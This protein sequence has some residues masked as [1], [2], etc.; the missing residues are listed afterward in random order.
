[1]IWKPVSNRIEDDDLF[2]CLPKPCRVRALRRVGLPLLLIGCPC[3]AQT[4]PARPAGVLPHDQNPPGLNVT[5]R[6]RG[7]KTTF[8]LFQAIPIELAFS[9]TK[10]SVYSIELDEAM[11][12]AGNTNSFEVSPADSVVLT[13]PAGATGAT[14]CC[15]SDRRYLSAQPTVLVRELTDYFRFEKPGT[16]SVQYFTR[17]VFRG[18]GSS[19]DFNASPLTVT[20]NVLALTIL[21]DDRDW[22]ARTLADVLAKLDDPRIR[23]SYIAGAKRNK[24]LD[25]ETAQDFAVENRL[26]QMEFALAQKTLNT[27][28]TEEAIH[29]RVHRMALESKSDRDASRR[30]GS[31]ALLPQP[32]L[33]ST[34]RPDLVATALKEQAEQPDFAVSGGYV[35]RWAQFLVQRD[36]PEIFRLNGDSYAENQDNLRHYATYLY[37]AERGLVQ[38]LDSLLPSKQREAAEATSV[39]I[40]V[41]RKFSAQEPASPP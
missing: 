35:Y 2:L 13:S 30:F 18:L 39:T 4:N 1:L 12:F 11:N 8:H 25:S 28:D 26:D 14:I 24:R 16:Y 37:E 21:D 3:A 38:M 5:L 17:R 6:T 15:A 41:V 36:H 19:N 7:A 20:S 40:R 22:D 23:Q 34:T 10:P 33:R 9:S 27:L 32:L 29:E 31:F